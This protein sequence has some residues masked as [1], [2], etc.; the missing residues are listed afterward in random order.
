M[1][2]V[3][4][5][6]MAVLFILAV[7]IVLGETSFSQEEPQSNLD[8]KHCLNAKRYPACCSYWVFDLGIGLSTSSNSFANS[9][10]RGANVIL[11]TDLG[12][13][14]N[15]NEKTSIGGTLFGAVGGDR[16]RAGV[17]FRYRRWLNDNTTLDFSPGILFIG[18]SSSGYGY[19][20][21]TGTS[22]RAELPAFIATTHISY[23][24][25][26]NA[27]VGIE[28]FPVNKQTQNL[29]PPYNIISSGKS[30]G[31]TFFIGAGLGQEPAVIAGG[32]GLIVIGVWI[33]AYLAGGG[34]D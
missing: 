28:L 1:L 19:D 2:L 22:S 16:E 15:R 10:S 9:Y 31:T 18:G 7:I 21:V 33:A 12:Y 27:Y 26:V 13:M 4:S 5:R 20:Y 6:R 17:R 14:I 8:C 11:F 34:Y 24:S 3:I 32:A 25:R 29:S 30:T 23:N